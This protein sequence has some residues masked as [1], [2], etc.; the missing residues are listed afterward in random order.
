MVAQL[1][2]PT[3][4]YNWW[5]VYGPFEAGEG[6]MPH[7]GHMIRWYREQRGW[8]IEDLAKA[9]G[10]QK[11]QAYALEE[12]IFMPKD[13]SRRQALIEL[14]RI[15]PLLLAVPF[16]ELVPVQSAGKLR[17][18]DPASFGRFEGILSLSWDTYY[19][20]SAQSATGLV[21][22]CIAE[23][24]GA[25]PATSG[26]ERDQLYGLKVRFLQLDGVI[27]RDRLDFERSLESS[28]S[29]IDLA[30]HLGNPELVASALFRRARTHLQMDQQALA[31]QDLEEALPFARRSR[32]ALRCYV[33]ICWAEVQSLLAPTDKQVQRAALAALDDVARTVRSAK[34]VLDGDG[35]FTRVDLPGLLMERTNVLRRFG[36]IEAAHDT[37][38]IVRENLGPALTRWQGNLR[39]A[40]AQL[41]LASGD[42]DG[43]CYM[44][45]EGLK[46]VRA[47][48]SKSNERKIDTIFRQLLTAQPR[49]SRVRDLGRE[50]G[51]TL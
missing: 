30:R 29:A 45:S 9:L 20:A 8:K 18:L 16:L 32:D 19:G 23:L 1:P 3:Q 37:L 6:M 48:R 7:I 27:G 10:V 13:I 38:A 41:C 33:F 49:H 5:S 31:A 51:Y 39:I 36:M 46:I 17:V 12:S 47:T 42:F 2:N 50:L 35:S 40:D 4:A 43:C 44:A 25:L 15:P 21:E 24:D 26:I 11:A 28:A 14:L 34:S 22:Q